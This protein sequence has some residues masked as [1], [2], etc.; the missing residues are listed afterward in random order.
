MSSYSR[1]TTEGDDCPFES[2]DKVLPPSCSTPEN[3]LDELCNAFKK[4][5]INSSPLLDHL[6]I[7]K[8][9]MMPSK[10]PIL[11]E[12]CNQIANRL[13]CYLRECICST[14]ALLSFDLDSIASLTC[15]CEVSAVHHHIG[16]LVGKYFK[17]NCEVVY[18]N[19][20]QRT[21]EYLIAVGADFE[22]TSGKDA[23]GFAVCTGLHSIRLIEDLPKDHIY[24]ILTHILSNLRGRSS[25]DSN[26]C[27]CQHV[28]DSFINR[29]SSL[30]SFTDHDIAQLMSSSHH[31]H[32]QCGETSSDEQ[33]CGEFQMY[34]I[35][36]FTPKI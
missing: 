34:F 17:E 36:M 6:L 11:S 29:H 24:C 26:H 2:E 5:Q 1:L 9:N 14:S 35:I 16:E 15:V 3:S 23:V 4:L 10:Q 25:D 19:E 12:M 28:T 22:G 13:V 27:Q 31:A 8:L 33:S 21:L 20:L 7:S 18:L 32:W 30:N